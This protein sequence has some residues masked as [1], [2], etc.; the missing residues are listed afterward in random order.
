MAPFP[1]AD[2]DTSA[3]EK[4]ILDMLWDKNGW[5]KR[6]EAIASLKENFVTMQSPFLR[7]NCILNAAKRKTFF[8]AKGVWGQT[9]GLTIGD[10]QAALDIA[11]LPN[12]VEALTSYDSDDHSLAEDVID[13]ANASE[14]M[15]NLT[16]IRRFIGGEE[17]DSCGSPISVGS[18]LTEI[19]ANHLQT[20]V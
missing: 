11:Y 1:P 13:T 8:F 20:D 4:H 16:D 14:A 5:V 9:L 17:Q 15:A 7:N 2:I 19:G 18:F 12:E 10:A 6:T 3:E